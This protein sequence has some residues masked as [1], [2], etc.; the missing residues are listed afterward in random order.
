M[1]IICTACG[2]I[3]RGGLCLPCNLREKNL[4]NYDLNAYSFDTNYIPQSQYDN[5]LCNLCGNNSH[6]G[7]DCQ[8]QFPFVYKQEP[9]YNQNYDDNYYSHD[10][11]SFPCCDY[12]GGS[13]ETFQ[14][15]PITQ[16]VD[17]SSYDQI[18]NPQYPDIHGKPLTNDEFKAYTI[19]NDA[20]MNDL[21]FK[22]DNLHQDFQKKFEQKREDFLNQ[23][24]NFM[25]N[26][27]DGPPIPPPGEDKE[28]EPT[29]DMELPS[30]EDIQ[31][32]P[33]QEPPQNFDIRRLIREECCVEVPEKQ[34]QK[35]EDTMF[36]LI[37]ICQEK[38][39]L[40]IHDDVDDLIESAL[41]SKLLLI[42]SNSQRLDKKEQEVKIFVE[43]PAECG[44]HSIQSLQNF[45]VVHKN[46]D[47]DFEDIEYIEDLL[48]DPETV[49]IEEENSVEAKNVVQQEEED[50]DLEDISQIQ[51]IVLREKL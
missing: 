24:R 22:L 43:Q 9:S 17:F 46:Y 31:P 11:Q 6:D 8:Q 36:E 18:Q 28:H 15:Q 48:F 30:T 7:Y 1:P 5:Y 50:I 12:C 13:H 42:N 2:G 16:N 29:T 25:Q 47:D 37:K 44:N 35:M 10:L 41:N 38:E 33:V 21:Q 32:L 4:Y 20:N 27:H 3:V 39:F 19:A 51:D 34:K 26:F 49:S 45:R 40:C 23:M 14:C